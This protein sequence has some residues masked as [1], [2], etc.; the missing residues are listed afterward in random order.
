MLLPNRHG[1]SD[2]YRYGFQ[3]QEKDDEIKGEGNSLN[4]KYRMHDPRV[5][6]FFAIDPLSKEYP[7]YS[8]YSFSGNKV[9]HKNELEGLEETNLIIYDN[10]QDAAALITAMNDGDVERVLL[11][12]NK[13]IRDGVADQHKWQNVTDDDVLQVSVVSSDNYST[14]SLFRAT[15]KHQSWLEKGLDNFFDKNTQG[16]TFTG[17]INFADGGNS[18]NGIAGSSR[19]GSGFTID[20]GGG[21]TAITSLLGRKVKPGEGLE[22]FADIAKRVNDAVKNSGVNFSSDGNSNIFMNKK[23]IIDKVATKDTKLIQKIK[24]DESGKVIN[25][26]SSLDQATKKDT[27]IVDN[28]QNHANIRKKDSEILSQKVDS[29]DF[30]NLRK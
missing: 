26:I 24:R 20:F 13:S 16:I 12:V 18:R 25:V 23:F 10:L 21:L 9:I 7:H 3:R 27:S 19:R 11:E 1:S 14:E 5:G 4:Y 28:R 15:S 8:P 22:N 29:S 30:F 17:G 6:R 2:K